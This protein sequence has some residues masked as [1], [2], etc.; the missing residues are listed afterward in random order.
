MVPHNFLLGYRHGIYEVF[1]QRSCCCIL[2]IHFY[3]SVYWTVTHSWLLLYIVNF[4]CLINRWWYIFPR[5]PTSKYS[6]SINKWIFKNNFVDFFDI[7]KTICLFSFASLNQ[8][9]IFF[10]SVNLQLSLDHFFIETFT[11]RDI[12]ARRNTQTF[13]TT[14][15]FAHPYNAICH[16][17]QSFTHRHDAIFIAHRKRQE[18]WDHNLLI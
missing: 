8:I 11:Q 5:C 15:Y 7:F 13:L 4:F 2:S 16:T 14:Q 18:Y 6:W 10:H 17:A 9:R 3:C 1:Q 12:F